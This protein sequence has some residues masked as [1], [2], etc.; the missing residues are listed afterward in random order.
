MSRD[1]VMVQWTSRH[2]RDK[3]ESGKRLAP[4]PERFFRWRFSYP[5][6]RLDPES[7]ANPRCV[8]G[9]AP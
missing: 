8:G 5:C 6:Q 7:A 4:E 9:A 2:R 1:R 3:H